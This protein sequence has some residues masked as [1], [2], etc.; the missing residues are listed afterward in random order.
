MKAVVKYANFWL[1]KINQIVQKQD[2]CACTAICFHEMWSCYVIVGYSRGRRRFLN[3]ISTC[4][5]HSASVF[6]YP[7]QTRNFWKRKLSVDLIYCSTLALWVFSY[8][9]VLRLDSTC[10]KSLKKAFI[11]ACICWKPYRDV[12]WYA[13]CPFTYL[14]TEFLKLPNEN[15]SQVYVS[16]VDLGVFH[17][18]NNSR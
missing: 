10:V 6:V 8:K 3:R 2:A 14:H 16:S 12:I 13:V 17:Y 7:S 4:S 11:R 9:F 5:Y 15:S 1:L 18:C